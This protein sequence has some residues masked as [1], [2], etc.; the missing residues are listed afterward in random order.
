M[1]FKPLFQF[2]DIFHS[3]L[4]SHDS[5][6]TIHDP[7]LDGSSATRPQVYPSHGSG[8]SDLLFVKTG[9]VI[10]L[11]Q[12]RKGAK[13]YMFLAR[14]VLLLIYFTFDGSSATRPQEIP[15]MARV[16]LIPNGTKADRFNSLL[17]THNSPH[18][19][20]LTTHHSPLTTHNS[21][22]TPHHLPAGARANAAAG[23]V[24]NHYCSTVFTI[25]FNLSPSNASSALLYASTLERS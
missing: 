23:G 1:L 6:F 25:S 20:L 13:K 7:F 18:Y 14:M 3:R 4:T 2:S 17:T 24:T 16:V 8:G 21:L 9:S 15:R 11:T 5:R 10:N 12:R 22:L 19:S